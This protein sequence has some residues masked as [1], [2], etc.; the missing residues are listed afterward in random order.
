MSKMGK[1]VCFLVRTIPLFLLLQ[2]I[3]GRWTTQYLLA[4]L[5]TFLWGVVGYIEGLAEK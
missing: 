4:L 2:S 3:T 1:I 5:T